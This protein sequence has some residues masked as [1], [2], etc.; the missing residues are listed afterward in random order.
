MR[1]LPSPFINLD[2]RGRETP[3]PSLW[4]YYRLP[5]KDLFA[6]L[7]HGLDPGN[8]IT[9]GALSRSFDFNVFHRLRTLRYARGCRLRALEA[10]SA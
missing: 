9:P 4:R 8:G 2:E 5:R 7:L 6:G 1:G 10:R 3:H